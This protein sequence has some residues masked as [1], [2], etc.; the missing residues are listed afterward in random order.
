[1]LHWK[2][3]VQYIFN[4]I[5]SGSEKEYVRKSVSTVDIVAEIYNSIFDIFVHYKAPYHELFSF[6]LFS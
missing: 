3:V 5:L 6:I 4:V 2:C 1:M